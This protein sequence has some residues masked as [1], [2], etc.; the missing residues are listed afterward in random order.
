MLLIG[1]KFGF[2]FRVRDRVEVEEERG[3]LPHPRVALNSQEGFRA[4]HDVWGPWKLL[5]SVFLFIFCHGKKEKLT[6]ILR[7]IVLVNVLL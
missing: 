4:Q 5:Q 6:K 7:C 1:L 2:G 3:D